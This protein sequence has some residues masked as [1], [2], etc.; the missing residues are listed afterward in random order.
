M[1]INERIQRR[2]GLPTE[3]EKPSP[4]TKHLLIFWPIVVA[5]LTNPIQFLKICFKLF[6]PLPSQHRQNPTCSKPVSFVLK[7]GPNSD[8]SLLY[9]LTGPG[10]L[11]PLSLWCGA[12]K[13]GGY[14]DFRSG[15]DSRL[16]EQ[17]ADYDRRR[18]AIEQ[19]PPEQQRMV[20]KFGIISNY[21]WSENRTRQYAVPARTDFGRYIRDQGF[22]LS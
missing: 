9:P 13:V 5:E 12:V 1:P 16:I 7:I 3:I 18:E 10:L 6:L 14:A 11:K 19:T 8:V 2:F 15:D 17:V 4:Q 22:D 20:K 21:G